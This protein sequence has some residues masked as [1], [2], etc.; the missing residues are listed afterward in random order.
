MKNMKGMKILR[1]RMNTDYQDG[2]LRRERGQQDSLSLDEEKVD[3]PSY[4][5]EGPEGDEYPSIGYVVTVEVSP[6]AI[7]SIRAET[8][9]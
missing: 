4:V 8:G 3:H 2:K 6:Y 9:P 5:G 7:Q 1:T